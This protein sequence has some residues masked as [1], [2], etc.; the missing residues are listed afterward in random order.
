MSEDEL[1]ACLRYQIA[2]IS[3][4]ARCFGSELSYVKPHGALY[5][6]LIANEQIRHK[7]V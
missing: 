7:C 3:G 4:L 2:A 1:V 6:D 5:N